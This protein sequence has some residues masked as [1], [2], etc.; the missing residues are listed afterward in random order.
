MKLSGVRGGLVLICVWLLVSGTNGQRVVWRDSVNLYAITPVLD[1]NHSRVGYRFSHDLEYSVA[2][3]GLLFINW[4]QGDHA[5]MVSLIQHL[6]YRT[7]FS[8]GNNTVIS[9]SII[10]DLGIQYYPD[11]ISRFQPDENTVDTRIEVGILKNISFSLLSTITTRI[12]NS[13]SYTVNHSGTLARTLGSAFLTPFLWTF[14]AGLGWNLLKTGTLNFGL[15]AA[16]FTWIRNSDIYLQQD[17]LEFYGVPKEKRYV[18]EYGL[19]LHFQ[20]DRTFL[21]RVQWNCDLLVF[22]SYLKD[23]DLILKNLI[24][25]RIGKYWKSSIQTRVCYDRDVSPKIQVENLVSFGFY[26]N[27]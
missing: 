26:F 10:H 27:M 24:G 18:F 5:S 13:Y 19:S 7:Q 21:N 4:Q 14:S 25:I 3:M 23:T 8:F 16:R 2:G 11:S 17:I 6:R 1:P 22:K 20:V 15:S 9:N 12:F